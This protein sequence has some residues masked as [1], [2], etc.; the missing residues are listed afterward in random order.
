MEPGLFEN[1]DIALVNTG[2][3]HPQGAIQHAGMMV[4]SKYTGRTAVAVFCRHSPTTVFYMKAALNIEDT[5][6]AGRWGCPLRTGT[7]PSSGP[8]AKPE[9]VN[10]IAGTLQ[11]A[12]PTRGTVQKFPG[13]VTGTVRV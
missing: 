11:R 8:A 5:M 6:N 1:G 9:R 7:L 12:A 13:G 10:L 3:P 2:G 4:R